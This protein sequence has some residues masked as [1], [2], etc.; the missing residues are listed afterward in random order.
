MSI[1]NKEVKQPSIFVCSFA[2]VKNN[3]F[4]ICGCSVHVIITHLKA[5]KHSYTKQG[6]T[7]FKKIFH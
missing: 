4:N 5:N 7:T 1:I 2:D 6:K 3:V